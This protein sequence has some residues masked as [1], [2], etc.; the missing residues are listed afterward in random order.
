LLTAEE[1]DRYHAQ[2]FLVCPGLV[3]RLACERLCVHLSATIAA[4]ASEYVAGAR[5]ELP[6]WDLMRRSRGGLEVF[7]DPSSGSPRDGLEAATMRVGH[8]LHAAD[9][10]FAAFCAAPAIRERFR[11]ILGGPGAVLASAV[12]YKQPRSE[13]VQFGMHQDAWYLTTAPDSLALAFV[14]LDDMSA[15]NGCLE[16]IPGSHRDPVAVVLRMG[17]DGFV[18][19]AG[20]M[21]R[22][23][24]RERGVALPVEKGS[25]IFLDGRTY[26]GSEPNRSSRPRR[27]LLLHGMGAGS[28]LAPTSWLVDD[29]APLPV[30]PM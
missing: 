16:V 2:G 21:P 11:Q 24:A 19:T 14:A 28:T 15:E 6:F 7:W 5:R 30:E 13:I 8:A 22:A 17:P 12:I 23:P 10:V 25:V 18:P 4:V 26:H 3:T 27:A 20:A 1:L 29:G 9:P